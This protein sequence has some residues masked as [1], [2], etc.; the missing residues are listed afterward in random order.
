MHFQLTVISNGC[1]WRKVECWRLFTPC[2][3]RAL[4][5]V[6]A[7]PDA[8]LKRVVLPTPTQNSRISQSGAPKMSKITATNARQKFG[9]FLE[10][11]QT[12][13]VHVQKYGRD[14]AV[15]VSATEYRRLK[16]SAPSINHHGFA[17]SFQTSPL[18]LGHS[19]ESGNPS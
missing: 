10:M 9:Q 7:Y 8:T 11:A 1:L 6:P 19:H 3:R 5:V 15:L 17:V 12:E 13:P 4:F 14:V 18:S 2:A 16:K